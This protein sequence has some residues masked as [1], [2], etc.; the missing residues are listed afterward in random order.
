ML[1]KSAAPLAVAFNVIA[2]KLD[3]W[4]HKMIDYLVLVQIVQY[5]LNAALLRAKAF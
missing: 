3:S 1:P 5:V 2:H 4:S